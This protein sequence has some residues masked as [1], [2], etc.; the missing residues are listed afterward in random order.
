MNFVQQPLSLAK[1]VKNCRSCFKILT[2]R[3]GDVSSAMIHREFFCWLP[4]YYTYRHDGSLFEVLYL[5]F[6]CFSSY[7]GLLR[8]CH[9]VFVYRLLSTKLEVNVILD[10]LFSPTVN[11]ITWKEI[12]A[13]KKKFE[14]FTLRPKNVT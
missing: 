1:H 5:I 10:S 11:P 13:P 6:V 9:Q 8:L 12:K 14:L 2:M 3:T 7:Y 4:V